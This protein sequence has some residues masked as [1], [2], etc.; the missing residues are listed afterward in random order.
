MKRR[1]LL[2]LIP[3]IRS[4]ETRICQ[5]CKQHFTVEPEDFLFYEKMLVPPPTFCPECRCERRLL[6]RN[7]RGLYRRACDLCGSHT[8]SMYRNDAPFVVYCNACWWSDRWDP[9][10]YGRDYM[11]ESSFFDQ[12]RELMKVVPR[13]AVVRYGDNPQC[14]YANFVKGSRNVY[15]GYSVVD[16][17]NVSY[18]YATD[19]SR[20]SLDVLFSRQL[21]WCYENVNGASNY[22]CVYLVQS[23]DCVQSS[24]LFDCSNCQQ[25]FMSTHLRNK[26]YVFRNEQLTKEEYEQRMK[27]I[28]FG[29]FEAFTRLK[30]EFSDMVRVTMHRFANIVKAT[31]SVGDNLSNVNNLFSAFNVYDSEFSRYVAR[32]FGLKEVYDVY[33]SPDCE[34]VYE[35]VVT[36]A[37][38]YQTAFF[39]HCEQLR[40]S[41]YTD[42]CHN[43]HHLFGCIGL[44]NKEYCVLNKRY[45][46]EEYASLI[47]RIIIHMNEVRYVDSRKRTYG[48]GEFFPYDISPFAYNETVAQDYFLL[49]R[50]AALSGGFSWRDFDSR[51]YR[52]TKTFQE[53]PDSISDVSQ[54]IVQ[55]VIQCV[56]D[57]LCGREL[58]SSCRANC[59]KAFRIIPQELDFYRSMELP[60]PRL[61]SNCRYYER[62]RWRNP[63][64]LWQR[65]CMCSSLPSNTQLTTAH[66]IYRNTG[67]HFHGEG[68]CSNEFFTAYSPDRPEVVYCEE[69][70]QAEVA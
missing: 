28:F 12:F 26:Q 43:A 11:W 39:S 70:Y 38:D 40:E 4:M 48:Y 37:R 2:C 58:T 60:L 24:F 15:L 17:E 34:L 10:Q 29:S 42:W 46:E 55:D 5:N 31:H 8:I 51:E 25:C 69:C 16:S 9:L 62:L 1:V 44:R 65:R 59:T 56:H 20:D 23:R 14:E 41:R 54:T 36:G 57:G 64:R 35:G 6:F 21:E 47:S 3:N 22:R 13:P 66:A 45:S 63:M 61:C 33:G 67:K 50:D 30:S 19:K 32:A 49:T 27:A 68:Q 52:V 53:L 18:S 7:E